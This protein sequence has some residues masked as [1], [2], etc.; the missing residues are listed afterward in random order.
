MID[1]S[2]SMGAAGPLALSALA[3]I[4]MALTRLEVGELAVCSFAENV[5]LLHP[6]GQ[7]L[8]EDAGAKVMGSFSFTAGRTM[9]GASLRAVQDVFSAARQSS[10]GGSS[11]ATNVLQLCFVVSDARI[12][13]DNRE[14]LDATVR[15]LAEQNILVVLI[16]I[17]KNADAKDSIFNTRSV[18]FRG[19]RVVTSAYLDNF[20]FPY[21]IAIQKLEAMPDVL[22]EALKGWFEL[23][24]SQLEG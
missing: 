10:T 4:S 17:D 21:Y 12:D 23:I 20:P 2:S 13:S 22:C 7:P 18:E 8:T 5:S 15:T 14:V 11:G 1:D 3:T 9:L 24:N 6:F 16:I 19:D